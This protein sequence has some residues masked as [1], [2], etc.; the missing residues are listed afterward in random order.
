MRTVLFILGSNCARLMDFLNVTLVFS[1]FP[2]YVRALGRRLQ[3][4][5]LYF[6]A[7]LRSCRGRRVR[8]DRETG[9]E[10]HAC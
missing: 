10:Y 2:L 5:H 1:T 8:A 9:T 6:F 3:I 7:L 4:Y